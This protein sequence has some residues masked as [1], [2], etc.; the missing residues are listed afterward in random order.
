[1]A[2]AIG[3]VRRKVLAPALDEVSFA[4][5][6]F[7]PAPAGATRRL[8]AI[9][10]SV[11]CGFEWGIEG[12]GLA[13]VERRV[14]LVEEGMRGFAYEG[15]AMACTVLDA[16]AGG[17]GRRTRELLRGPAAPHLF[18]AYIGIGF[19]MTRLPRKLWKNVLPDLPETPLHPTMSWLAVDG[20]GFDLAYFRT[21]RWVDD[22]RVP[23]AHPWGGFP[24]YFPRAVDQGIGR[25]LWFVHGAQVDAV[26]AAVR[27]FPVPRQ[28]DLWSGVGLAATFAGGCDSANLTALRGHSGAH[29][30]ELGLGA[31]F[32]AKARTYAG[33]V[34]E[35]TGIAVT[36]L[37]DRTVA[38]AVALADR[39]EITEDSPELPAY[40]LWR[41]RIRDGIADRQGDS[42]PPQPGSRSGVPTAR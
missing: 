2:T 13:E 20:Y 4:A 41:Q 7:P 39:T 24:E 12:S 9:P 1:M 25:A 37:T 17:R 28:A 16:F 6:G 30:D 34:P 21:R 5:R 32:A 11:V 10:Q 23:A 19:A 35:E 15:V 38:G 14:A 36:A 18:L 8:E 31:V 22:Q 40:E 33:F 26:A 3:L 42:S 27:R 29:A